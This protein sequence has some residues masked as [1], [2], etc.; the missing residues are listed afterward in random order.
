MLTI[1]KKCILELAR[2]NGSAISKLRLTKLLFLVSQE[3]RIYDFVPYHYGPFSFQMYH[4]LADLV[5]KGYVSD[6]GNV[7]HLLRARSLALPA[8]LQSVIDRHMSVFGS[9]TDEELIERIY[10][11][12][13]WYT[14]LSLNDKK[15][16]YHRNST[17]I[18]T[19]GYEEKTIDGFLNELLSKEIG[20]VIDV[21][22]NPFSYKFGFSKAT[23]REYLSKLSIE[24]LHMP[25]MGIP[26]KVRRGVK[27]DADLISL[28]RAYEASL[29]G[30][31]Q[32]LNFIIKAGTEKK[33]VL[34]CME[35]DVNRCHR[36]VIAHRLRLMGHEVTDL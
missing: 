8:P 18:A 9:S 15:M 31:N 4:D 32:S 11:N 7:V 36:G 28:F 13:P 1:G 34:M 27:T 10:S 19:I 33:I 22:N 26:S 23:L 24:Y 2:A 29:N 25:E 12:N 35:K 21:R 20:L 3:Q 16:D 5:R 14:I 17:G 6:D 30:M